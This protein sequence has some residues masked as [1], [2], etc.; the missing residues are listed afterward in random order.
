MADGMAVGQHGCGGQHRGGQAA[1]RPASAARIRQDV[2]QDVSGRGY[3]QVGDVP[4]RDRRH[5]TRPRTASAT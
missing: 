1:R 2:R 4:D 3:G 5:H